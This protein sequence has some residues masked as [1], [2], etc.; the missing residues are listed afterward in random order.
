MK[1][2]E[3]AFMGYPVT[4]RERAEQFYGELLGLTET[5]KDVDI[6]EMPGIFWIEYDLGNTT[7]AISNAWAPSGAE[8]PTLA[9]EVDDF[10]AAIQRL[11]EAGVTFQAEKIE[12]PVCVFAIITD[13]DGNGLMI[14]KRHEAG[15]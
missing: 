8:G 12:S 3:A 10:D 4:D 6:P 11:K 15:G 2:T 9:L 13:P 14:H 7:L 5:M 1:V